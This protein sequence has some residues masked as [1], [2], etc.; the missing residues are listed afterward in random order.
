MPIMHQALFQVLQI[1]QNTKKISALMER[2]YILVGVRDTKQDK[3]LINYMVY[4]KV[5]GAMG[6]Q[7]RED[8][9][10]GVGASCD[11]K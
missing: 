10:Y 9:E 3:L 8:W 4:C 1:H 2:E 11:S 6:K 7:E 5:I